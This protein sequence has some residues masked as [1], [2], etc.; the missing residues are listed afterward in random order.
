[1]LLKFATKQVSIPEIIIQTFDYNAYENKHLNNQ[2]GTTGFE[3]ILCSQG[4]TKCKQ[5][6][7]ILGFLFVDSDVNILYAVVIGPTQDL[8]VLGI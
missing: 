3:S 2:K 4:I 8:F 7:I 6:A 1:M 5:T